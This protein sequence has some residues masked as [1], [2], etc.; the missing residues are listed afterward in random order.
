MEE[1]TP[2]KDCKWSVIRRAGNGSVTYESPTCTHPNLGVS[3]VTGQTLYE[4]E[5]LCREVRAGKIKEI[6]QNNERCS[7]FHGIGRIEEIG[8]ALRVSNLIAPTTKSFVKSSDTFN[9]CAHCKWGRVKVWEMPICVHPQ[10]VEQ[11]PFEPDRHYTGS[12]KKQKVS[13]K[14]VRTESHILKQT[15]NQ[16]DGFQP[17]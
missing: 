6:A 8:K 11:A 3:V 7:G 15:G 9:V 16:C 2:C 14:K 12:N 13:A 10:V 5:R 4:K 1:N 17:S